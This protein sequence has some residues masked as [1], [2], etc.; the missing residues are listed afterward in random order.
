MKYHHSIQNLNEQPRFKDSD[1]ISVCKN[2]L[3]V[4][5]FVDHRRKARVTEAESNKK[6]YE[7]WV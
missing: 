4:T 5:E 6:I 3:L 2:E 7:L 1:S